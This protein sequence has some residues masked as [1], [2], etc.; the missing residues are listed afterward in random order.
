MDRIVEKP[1]LQERLITKD[2]EI[3][4]AVPM[5]ITTEKPVIIEVKVP[6]AQI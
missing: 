4:K 6:Y 5:Y 2:V 1:L 3:E